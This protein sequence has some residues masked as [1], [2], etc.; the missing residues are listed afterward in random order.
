MAINTLRGRLTAWYVLAQA[1]AL[2]VFALLLCVWLG[3]TLSRHHDRE[4]AASAAHLA[5]RLAQAPSTAEPLSEI[6]GSDHDGLRFVMLRR[7]DGTLIY[8]S[9]S[10]DR[11]APDIGHHEVFVHAASTA[12]VPQFFTADLPTGRARFQCV[13]VATTPPAY[14]QVGIVLGDLESTLQ[15]VGWLS[16]GLIPAVLLLTSYGGLAVAR[17]ALRPMVAV[18]RQ[19]QTLQAADLAQRIAV[20]SGGEEIDALVSSVNR[21]LARLQRAF[22][23]QREFTADASHQ[24]RTPLAIMRT[25]I[26][27]A[28]SASRDGER[29]A[30]VLEDLARDTD[31]LAATVAALADFG[32]ADQ[33]GGLGTSP[34]VDFSAI[35]QE[36]VDIL[37]ALA[38]A[39][40]VILQVTVAPGLRLCGVAARLK[41]VVLNLGD[42]AIKYTPAGRHVAVELSREA[43]R[44]C[45]TV[46]DGGVGIAHD[47][48]GKIFNRF[49][50]APGALAEGR[51]LGLAIVRRVVEAH[52]GSVE[53]H[54]RVGHGS[55]FRV[56][57]PVTPSD[58]GPPPAWW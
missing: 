29:D 6:L 51:G 27:A 43:D 41:Q 56:V 39:K 18:E 42:N 57:F 1:V 36:A 14:L 21:L 22:E 25:A 44:V 49:H 47:Q 58:V 11:L 32:V 34:I 16:V 10:L 19:L 17:R 5:A 13:P 8:R 12:R 3:Y 9:P 15:T 52:G 30:R 24:L 31:D 45:L 2:S 48:L 53:V 38:D 54:S 7:P 4:L 46:S 20:P 33:V 35:C 23:A 55:D 26:D 50:R 28:L 40:G 37:Q